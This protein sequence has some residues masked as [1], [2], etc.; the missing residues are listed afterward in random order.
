MCS[1]TRLVHRCCDPLLLFGRA[2]TYKTQ[3]TDRVMGAMMIIIIVRSWLRCA[4][5]EQKR[6]QYTGNH[7]IDLVLARSNCHLVS[8]SSYTLENTE[9]KSLCTIES[10][11]LRIDLEARIHDQAAS[12]TTLP[13]RMGAAASMPIPLRQLGA[14]KVPESVVAH[15]RNE[16]APIDE[17]TQEN[18]LFLSEG[19]REGGDHGIDD[20]TTF[21]ATH[22]RPIPNQR[23]LSARVL[24]ELPPLHAHK[25]RML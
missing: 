11:T 24:S 15:P 22:R 8:T 6:S 20:R 5:R 2:R 19:G 16:S 3:R 25:K 21:A 7:L 1:S 10:I 9:R 12:G 13:L 18:V 14:L 4:G 23:A 17:P